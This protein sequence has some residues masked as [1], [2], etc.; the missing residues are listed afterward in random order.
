VPSSS[1][2]LSCRSSDCGREANTLGGVRVG[3]KP[4]KS[5]DIGELTGNKTQ[6]EKDAAKQE[7]KARFRRAVQKGVG[8]VERALDK[9]EDPLN[10]ARGR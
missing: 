6:Q 5:K 2:S 9:T 10:E 4:V 3:I 7:W 1:S 8:N